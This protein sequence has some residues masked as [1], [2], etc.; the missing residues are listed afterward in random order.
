MAIVHRGISTNYYHPWS[1]INNADL[2]FKFDNI[3]IFGELWAVDSVGG[4]DS[5]NSYCLCGMFVCFITT[6]G[7]CT[8]NACLWKQNV[9]CMSSFFKTA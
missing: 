5:V 8:L 3:V 6:N 9:P 2:L 7:L 4:T 1:V